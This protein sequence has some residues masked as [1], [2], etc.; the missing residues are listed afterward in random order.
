[1]TAAEWLIAGAAFVL[2]ALLGSFVEYGV[3]RLMHWRILLGRVHTRHHK[4]GEGDGAV[5]EWLY[6]MAGAG[7]AAAA[8]IYLGFQFHF[9][10]LALPFALGSLTYGTFAA[11]AHQLQHDRPEL[12]FWMPMPVHYIH[13]REQQWRENFGIATD[14]WDRVFGTYRRVPFTPPPGPSAIWDY[15]RVKWL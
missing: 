14:L 9:E 15:F 3:H 11:Y 1:M 5:W 10:L 8:F 2:G 4:H 12:V 6:Y 13:H 7:P